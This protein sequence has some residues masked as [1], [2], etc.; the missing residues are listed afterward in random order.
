MKN[1]LRTLLHAIKLFLLYSLA[2]VI[3]V[4][5][6]CLDV[7]ITGGQFGELSFV[8]ITQEIM[9][10]GV[11]V[12][13]SRLAVKNTEIRQSC[14]LITGF[15][16]CMFIRELDALFDL[17]SHGFWLYPALVA[18]GISLLLIS[19]NLKQTLIQLAEY[20][21]S[22]S[23]GFMMSGLICILVFSRLFGM[24]YI[25]Y[26]IGPEDSKYLLYRIKSAAE[27]G[28]EL[29]GYSLCFISA[30]HYSKAIR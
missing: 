10:L 7:K 5:M 26:G 4:G 18:T 14:I 17:I 8:E 15:F 2:A 27:E 13:F 19:F 21:R 24:K 30:F 11:V 12:I 9:I 20:T 3:A 6:L 29:F 22:P 23:Y 25:W 28:S 16:T 1:E